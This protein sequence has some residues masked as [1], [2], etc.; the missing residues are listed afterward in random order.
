VVNYTLREAKEGRTPNP[1]IMCNSFIKFGAF[2]EYI[3]K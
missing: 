1:D 3:G 2:Y